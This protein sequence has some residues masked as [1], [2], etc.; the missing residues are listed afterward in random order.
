MKTKKL[1]KKL[2]LKGG[3]VIDP[4]RNQ[5]SKSDVLIENGKIKEIG[6]IKDK[7]GV[8]VIDCDGLIVTHGFCDIHVHFR[9]PGR[10]DKETLATGSQAALAGGFTR[11]C[12]MPNTNPPLDTPESV[13]FIVEK[14][15][16]LPIYVHP[17]GA[18]TKGQKGLEITEMG[19]MHKEGAV[20]FSDDGLPIANGKV[21][22]LA[23]EY[24]RMIGVPV[25]NHAEDPLLRDDGLMNESVI[26][27]KLGLPGNPDIAESTMVQRD[28]ALAEYCNAKVHIPHV[29]SFKSVEL[30]RQYS[31]TD[32][33]VT[34]E[35]TPHHLYFNDEALLT[36]DTNL[37]VAPP[38]RNEANRKLLVRAIKDGIITCIASDHAPHTIEDK[39]GT[40]DLAPFGMIGLETSFGAVNKILT[41]EAKL[42]VEDILQFFT[43]NPRNI[44]GFNNDL[45]AQNTM[46]ELVIIDPTERWTFEE[47][48]IKSRSKNSPFVGLDLLGRPKYV[49]TKDRIT[50]IH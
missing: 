47:N 33:A 35:I 48:N 15:Q 2:V 49:L 8:E 34:A 37:K 43:T 18:V 19:A 42:T 13:R 6:V 30:I 4:F 10:E 50:T 45:F 7:Y 20:A 17:V 12:V 41:E 28:L 27:T 23:L 36:Y 46:V 40:F 38:I 9:E 24:T 25:I 22:Q 1:S 5:S 11:V 29:S 21:M 39:E 14:S 26:S 3:T 44:M 16:D 32:L 31:S